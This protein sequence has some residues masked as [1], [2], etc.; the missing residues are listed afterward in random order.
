MQERQ[1]PAHKYLVVMVNNGKETVI[2]KVANV[3]SAKLVLRDVATRFRTGFVYKNKG[4]G[5]HTTR[6]PMPDGNDIM[7]DIRRVY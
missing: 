6:I 5:K 3:E 1:R 7:L 2:E 4:D